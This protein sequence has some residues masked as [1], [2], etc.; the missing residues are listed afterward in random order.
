MVVGLI[1]PN[2]VSPEDKTD[3]PIARATPAGP[4]ILIVASAA[5]RAA[6]SP[7]RAN[8]V[9][10]V[11]PSPLNSSLA[12]ARLAAKL[13]TLSKLPTTGTDLP[14]PSINASAAFDALIIA[15]IASGVLEAFFMPETAATTSTGAKF[16][17]LI[18]TTALSASLALSAEV[19]L[20]E[21]TLRMLIIF[22]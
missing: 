2:N 1:T 8:A 5:A 13:E 9:P 14:T 4:D 3:K 11:T 12:F 19:P 17:L 7:N 20:V 6:A 15:A 18:A 10:L 16:R 21:I 22:P